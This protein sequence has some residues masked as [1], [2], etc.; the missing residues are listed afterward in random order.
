[1][2]VPLPTLDEAEVA[3]IGAGPAGAAA[4]ITLAQLGHEVILVDQSEFPRDKPCGGALWSRAVR[5]LLELGLEELVESARPVEGTRLLRT[6]DGRPIER[7]AGRRP[8]PRCIPRLRL[9]AAMFDI[10]L[11]CGARFV[12]GRVQD[13]VKQDGR[14]TAVVLYGPDGQPGEVRAHNFIA[15][16]GATSRMRH[17]LHIG[18]S[19]SNVRA[20]AMRQEFRTEKPPENWFEIQTPLRSR[21]GSLPGY[22]WIFP[23]T[24][25][26]VSIG[27]GLFRDLS[28]A[29]SVRVDLRDV[30]GNF[31]D[32]IRSSASTRFGN[33]TGSAKPSGAPVAIG[34]SPQAAQ[35]SNV[36]FVGD[37]AR[38]VDPLIGE[39][40]VAAL[41]GGRAAAREV[42]GWLKRG[43]RAGFGERLTNEFPRLG[44]DTGVVI[45]NY[46]WLVDDTGIFFDDAAGVRGGHPFLEHV[47]AISMRGADDAPT[48]EVTDVY[49]LLATRSD[50]VRSAMI[51]IS[52]QIL[53]ALRTKLPYAL[54]LLH[55][56]FRSGVGPT[57]SATLLSVET[58]WGKPF[59]KRSLA[60]AVAG[61]LLVVATHFL[62]QTAEESEFDHKNLGNALATL[63]ADHALSH[64]LQIATRLGPHETARFA[65]LA[66]TNYE[67]A[68]A[69][70]DDAWA[71]DRS[72]ERYLTAIGDSAGSLH[73]YAADLGARLAGR[74]DAAAG[75]SEFGFELG[76]ALKISNDLV[77]LMAGD[78]ETAVEPGEVLLHGDYAL[79]VIYAL[80]QDPTLRTLLARDAIGDAQTEAV[81]RIRESSAVERCVAECER[82]ADAARAALD[83]VQL[84]DATTLRDLALLPVERCRAHLPDQADRTTG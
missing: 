82:H 80:E 11:E 73:A 58:A 25:D 60:A 43:R 7:A 13:A 36:L 48:I 66:R 14:V 62:S 59:T 53:V 55:R 44:Q 4:A 42:D 26:I 15:A 16:D 2:S 46:D 24:D 83:R 47:A 77:E 78:Y 49:R 54:D 10:A 9:D 32:D 28:A 57:A 50:G 72:P 68:M 71:L 79:P 20:Y 33:L 41:E 34:F 8:L 63:I 19:K 27:V 17:L 18:P 3:V 69:E 38:M 5:S 76:V 70:V 52:D 1:M 23:A 21:H 74:D 39:G 31:V 56:R 81:A 75:L 64:G 29:R 30:L 6:Q 40:I 22:S 61:E 51:K 84:P 12:R 65:R 37:A 45:R 35:R 67:G